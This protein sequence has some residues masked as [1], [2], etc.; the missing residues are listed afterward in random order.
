M[1]IAATGELIFQVN[2]VLAHF[3]RD[4]TF[5]RTSNGVKI[6]DKCPGISILNQN[7]L[8]AVPPLLQP[9]LSPSATGCRE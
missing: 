1:A 8:H 5:E 6:R 3:E 4:L 9:G 2:G 7:A